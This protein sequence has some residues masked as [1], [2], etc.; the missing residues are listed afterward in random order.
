MIC[1]IS[2]SL[3]NFLA[4]TKIFQDPKKIIRQHQVHS[5]GA[6]TDSKKE[7]TNSF[8]NLCG[9]FLLWSYQLI[10]LKVIK[11]KTYFA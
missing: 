5:T 9:C 3:N 8:W 7:K 10:L 11:K 2:N 4:L 1:G 6:P